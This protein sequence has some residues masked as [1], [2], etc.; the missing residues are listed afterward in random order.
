MMAEI[1]SVPLALLISG[2]KSPRTF[3]RFGAATNGIEGTRI[4]GHGNVS[5]ERGRVKGKFSRA[6]RGV[7]VRTRICST[8]GR[9]FRSQCSGKLEH[10]IVFCGVSH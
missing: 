9:V 6:D 1:C 3:H 8:G 10:C 5:T 2:P 7:V 4:I